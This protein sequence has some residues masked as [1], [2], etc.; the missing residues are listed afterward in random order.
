MV[1]AAPLEVAERLGV[2][3]VAGAA[4]S[5]AGLGCFRAR[6][7]ADA[8]GAAPVD[9]DARVVGGLLVGVPGLVACGQTVRKAMSGGSRRPPSCHTHPSVSPGFGSWLPAP[10]VA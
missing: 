4:E 7:V 8:V 9:A 3:L 2:A 1:V 5:V 6:D 10:L